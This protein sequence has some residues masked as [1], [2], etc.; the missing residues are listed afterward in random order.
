MEVPILIELL[1]YLKYREFK[2]YLFLRTLLIIAKDL[3]F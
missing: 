2:R 3:K 1:F